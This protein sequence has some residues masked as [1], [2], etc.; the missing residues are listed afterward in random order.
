M[1]CILCICL[2]SVKKLVLKNFISSSGSV[3]GVSNKIKV[4]EKT[5]L[6]PITDYSKT[7]MVGKK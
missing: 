3:Y 6:L 5:D 7:K 2:M 4:D 1:F